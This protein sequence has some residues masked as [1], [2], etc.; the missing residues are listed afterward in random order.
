MHAEYIN[1][2][3]R[4]PVLFQG[5]KKKKKILHSLQKES[6][7]HSERLIFNVPAPVKFCTLHF[8]GDFTINIRWALNLNQVLV[9]YY[10]CASVPRLRMYLRI[11]ATD[12][13]FITQPASSGAISIPDPH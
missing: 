13:D 4:H 12:L 10:F 9:L 3:T 11:A 1:K 8:T 7:I 6:N 5:T 2:T